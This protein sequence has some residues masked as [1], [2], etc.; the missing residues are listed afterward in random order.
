[1]TVQEV[2]DAL[3]NLPNNAVVKISLNGATCCPADDILHDSYGV[4]LVSWS[5]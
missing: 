2:I 5:R 1:V 3:G 4:V